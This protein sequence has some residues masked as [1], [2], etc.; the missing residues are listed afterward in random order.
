M[1]KKKKERT[2]ISFDW[3]VKRILR[4]KANFGIL[5]G[6]LSELLKKDIC[7]NSILESESNKEHAS[8]KSNQVDLLCEDSNGEL[9][10]I[11][12]QFYEE[13]DY[14]QRILYGI[15][16]VISEHISLGKPYADVKKVYSIN[17]LYFDIG[18]GEDYVY[19]GKMDFFGIHHNDKLSLGWAQKKNFSR[20]YPSDIFPEV[21]L[22]KVNNFDDIA[23]TP[24]DEWIYFLKNTNLPK[25]YSAKGLN[26][27][28]EKLNYDKMDATTKQQYD[29][30][31]TN[32]KV[33]NSALE[34]ASLK[35]KHEGRQEGRQ[36]ERQNLI[37]KM[38][39]LGQE[40]NFIAKV[41][42]M[43]EKEV[44]QILR[45]NGKNVQ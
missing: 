31:L 37:L 39:D 4:Q 12:V 28:N 7:I 11:E 35:G 45:K 19:H 18:E 30:Y 10:I 2:Y 44:I 21:Y 23:K 32:V 38:Y 36:E 17:I 20:E 5:E 14:F 9:M 26:Q 13:I 40:I 33:S 1:A 29:E 24:L 16:K 6:F 8:D 41:L 22:L 43:S 34:T 25:K 27:L 3:A 42:E 15:S